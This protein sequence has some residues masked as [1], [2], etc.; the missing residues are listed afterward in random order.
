MRKLLVVSFFVFLYQLCLASDDLP[1]G[2]FLPDGSWQARNNKATIIEPETPIETPFD[3]STIWGTDQRLSYTT[4]ERIHDPEIAVWGNYVYVVWWNVHDV[5]EDLAR[6][7]DL[8]QSWEPQRRITSDSISVGYLPQIAVW[9]SSV[10]VVYRGGG[11]GNGAYLSKSTDYGVT[12]DSRP[13]Y[14]SARNYAETPTVVARRNRVYCTFSIEVDFVPP[15][16]DWDQ[17]LY[18]STDYGNTWCDT[19]FVS[20]SIYS[21]IGPDM[22]INCIGREPDPYLHII[23]QI[24]T[25]NNSTQEIFYQKSNDGGETW[26]SAIMISGNDTIDSQWPQISAWGDSKVIATWMDYKYTNQ[27]WTGDAFIARSTNNGDSWSI[28]IPLTSSHLVKSCDINASGDTVVLAYDEGPLEGYKRI[29]TNVSFDGGENWQGPMLVSDS[30]PLAYRVESCVALGGGYAHVAWGDARDL[31]GQAGDVEAYYDRGC[32]DSNSQG[33]SWDEEGPKPEGIAPKAYPN[34]F[35]SATAITLTGAE[36]A[37]IAIYDI[38]GRLISTLHTVGGQAFWDAGAY[39]SG[40]YFA[41][42]SGDKA[43]TIKLVLMK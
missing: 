43:T 2:R 31:G 13:I 9:D 6:S 11:W 34:P 24:G 12:W 18:R 40:L 22:T 42:A 4:M 8:G 23:R 1:P 32:L 20:D 3:E 30:L 10:Y 26:S 17:Y 19:F 14:Y 5:L 15:N 33:I 25:T 27:G 7:T 16:Q 41:R 39:S 37:E 38:T 29:Y 35:N 21:G 36:Q 28:P